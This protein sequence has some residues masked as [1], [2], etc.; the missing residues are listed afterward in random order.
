MAST[1][2]LVPIT[3]N[4]LASFYDKYPFQSLSDDV[5]RLSYQIRSM[6]SDLHNDSPLTPGLN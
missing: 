2:G 1:E 4:F 5:S 3:R 6:A